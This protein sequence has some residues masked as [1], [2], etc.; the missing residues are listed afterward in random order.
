[1]PHRCRHSS[2]TLSCRIWTRPLTLQDNACLTDIFAP[3]PSQVAGISNGEWLYRRRT[4]SLHSSTN[5]PVPFNR[6]G[7]M[8]SQAP[9]LQFRRSRL[10]TEGLSRPRARRKFPSAVS[11]AFLAACPASVA[12]LRCVPMLN[13][14]VAPTRDT[15][16]GQ[17]AASEAEWMLGAVSTGLRIASPPC[18]TP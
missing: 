16:R 5:R 1:M 17:V 10:A 2:A 9:A 3:Q 8:D 7:K 15:I 18:L 12:H 14:V 6:F 11:R 4:L 13:G